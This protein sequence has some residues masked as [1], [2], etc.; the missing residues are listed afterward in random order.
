MQPTQIRK[1]LFLRSKCRH[2]FYYGGLIFPACVVLYLLL[3]FCTIH[4]KARK[5]LK[6]EPSSKNYRFLNSIILHIIIGK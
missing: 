2:L 5:D 6:G 1:E 3:C 4:T